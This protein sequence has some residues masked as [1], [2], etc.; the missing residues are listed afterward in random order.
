M[1]ATTQLSRKGS[2]HSS[3]D[4]EKTYV[5]Q[6][7]HVE[8]PPTITEEDE[9]NHAGLHEYLEGADL[10]ITPKIVRW[11]LLDLCKSDCSSACIRR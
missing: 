1:S 4:L 9:R 5:K 11:A 2:E 7:E 8:H 10:E 3:L 6:S